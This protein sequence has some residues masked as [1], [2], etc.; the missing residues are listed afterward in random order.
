MANYQPQD[1]EEPEEHV[2][3]DMPPPAIFSPQDIPIPYG[4][5]QNPTAAKAR[6]AQGDAATAA[7]ALPPRQFL[8]YLTMADEHVPTAPNENVYSNDD[9]LELKSKLETL[10]AQCP[11][12]TRR[13]LANTLGVQRDMPALKFALAHVAYVWRAGPW[14]DLYC[15]FGVDPRKD[16]ALR[17]HQAVYFA[18]RSKNELPDGVTRYV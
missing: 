4:Y 6:A 12:W 18:Q 3:I 10:F 2:L 1:D 5:V 15:V 17:V 11:M 7:S 9:V 16:P 13:K 8:F 14:R